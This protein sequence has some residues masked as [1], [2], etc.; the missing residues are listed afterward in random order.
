MYALSLIKEFIIHITKI[1]FRNENDRYIGNFKKNI[2]NRNIRETDLSAVLN[3]YVLL[4]S[5]KNLISVKSPGAGSKKNSSKSTVSDY[6][7][8]TSV[9]KKRGNLL[10]GIVYEF[11][12]DLIIELGTSL[13]ISA[14]YMS[15]A[16]PLTRVIT[17]EGN[18]QI[19]DIAASN[20]QKCG[21]NNINVINR[22]FDDVISDLVKEVNA[23]TMVFIDGNHGFDATLRYFRAFSEVMLIVIDDIRWSEEMMKAWKQ[24]RL[25]VRHATIIDLFDMGIILKGGT[26]KEY[27]LWR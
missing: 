3:Y 13:G 21:Y 23:N 9:S 5:D 6:A 2:L 18:P 16:N 8:L 12:P 10:Y 22:L 11:K 27:A 19:A 20:L 17:V 4:R 14:M 26:E 24:I 15:A 1:L 7:Q 25:S